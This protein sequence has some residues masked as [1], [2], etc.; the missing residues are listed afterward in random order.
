M[1]SIALLFI[2]AFILFYFLIY[3]KVKKEKEEEKEEVKLFF[4]KIARFA[5]II[6]FKNCAYYNGLYITADYIIFENLKIKHYKDLNFIR[7]II[8]T[9]H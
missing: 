1:V 8:K 7:Q 3:L 4:D 9:I 2:G 5:P 6:Q